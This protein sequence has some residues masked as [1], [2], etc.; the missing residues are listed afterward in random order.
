MNHRTVLFN[1][2]SPLAPLLHR[3]M[4]KAPHSDLPSP[5]GLQVARSS[6]HSEY[7]SVGVEEMEKYF[8]KSIFV[9]VL[10]SFILFNSEKVC[11]VEEVEDGKDAREEN[12]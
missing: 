2:H 10:C 7:G 12:T 11:P 9:N 4:T 3:M 1:I 6:F 8:Y 5:N